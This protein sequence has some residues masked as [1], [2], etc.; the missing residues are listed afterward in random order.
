MVY[1]TQNNFSSN[2]TRMKC[3]FDEIQE[4]NISKVLNFVLIIQNYTHTEHQELSM[5]IKLGT[6]ERAILVPIDAF[7]LI[8][9]IW[10]NEN[11]DDWWYN[12]FFSVDWFVQYNFVSMFFIRIP[13]LVMVPISHC[14]LT[15]NDCVMFIMSTD[16]FVNIELLIICIHLAIPGDVY[17][18]SP[19]IQNFGTTRKSSTKRFHG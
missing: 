18:L 15:F 5:K 6:E 19:R 3:K 8:E 12:N 4:C 1:V 9:S 11:H 10:L 17:V 2:W 14:I 13:W 16:K 7:I